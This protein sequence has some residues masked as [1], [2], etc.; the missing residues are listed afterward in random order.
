MLR[1][2]HIENIAVIERTDISFTVGLNVLTGETGAGKSIIIDAIQ[3]VMGA[4][5]NKELIRGGAEGAVA[6]AT[7]I[8]DRA[9]ER[10]KL[11]DIDCCDE[12]ILQR[13]FYNDGKTSCRVNGMPVTVKQLKE[14][15]SLLLDIHGQNDG[16]QLMDEA[17]HREFL[18]SYGNYKALITDYAA[19]YNELMETKKEISRLSMNEAEKERLIGNLTATLAELEMAELREGE[20]EGLESRIELLRNSEKL[21]EALSSAYNALY[22]GDS[23]AVSLAENAAA[24]TGR[25][26]QFSE[27]LFPLKK[28]INEA[29]LLLRDAAETIDDFLRDLDFS[30]EEFDKIESRLA[31]IKRL[32]KKYACGTSELITMLDNIRVRLDEIELSDHSL[33]KLKTQLNQQTGELLKLAEIL[34]A[35]RL[36]AALKLEK[37]IETELM[38]LSMPS[39]CFVVDIT[40]LGEADF[41]S[42]GADK[43]RFLISANRGE[44]PGPIS[45]VASGGEL[46]RIMLAI[47]S[48]FSSNDDRETLV[49]DE[50]D[51][52]VSGV[53]AQ[54]VGE[55]LAKLSKTRQVICVTHLPQIAAMADTHFLI[56]KSESVERT[57]TEVT[58]L[59]H[60]GR[61][62]ELARLHGGENISATTLKSAEEQLDA[63]SSFKVGI[64]EQ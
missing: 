37:Q 32:K 11:N 44:K 15:S 17:Q 61:K 62:R 58:K 3:S 30:P 8:T 43:V 48:V 10:L 5:G 60:E 55:K 23:N 20:E 57:F 45:K 34:S 18:D 46:S 40:P 26:A 29:S 38:S 1:D 28:T 14:L 22:E 47:K 31:F 35:E 36:D 54:R 21:T 4:R 63:A 27:S 9:D 56:N 2:L 39:V 24:E 51:S 6:T 41:D 64:Q 13:R 52:G 50:I 33:E 42:S 16:R 12:L 7:F 59:D 49:F 25:A 53:A 19:A